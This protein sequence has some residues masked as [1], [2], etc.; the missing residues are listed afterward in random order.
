M[1][2]RWKPN[3]TA[4]KDGTAILVY[5]PPDKYTD[6]GICLVEWRTHQLSYP[7]CRPMWAWCLPQSDQDE[8]GGA[9]TV[10]PTHW[11]ELPEPPRK[12][13]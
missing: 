11:M 7:G 13:K 9:A 6:G 5:E 10:Q 12:K 1:T 4:P 2:R 3:E 8:Q